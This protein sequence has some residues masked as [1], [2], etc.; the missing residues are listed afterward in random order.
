MFK[1]NFKNIKNVNV[2]NTFPAVE[3]PV[4]D[5]PGIFYDAVAN[6]F[7]LPFMT[8]TAALNF[9]LNSLQ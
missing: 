8:M 6:Y 4:Q 2:L 7:L 3:L 1:K 5:L 9:K